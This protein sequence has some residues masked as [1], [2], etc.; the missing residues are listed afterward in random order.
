MSKKIQITSK[1]AA[2]FNFMLKQLRKIAK[3]YQTPKQLRRTDEKQLG[4]SYEECLEMAYENIQLEAARGAK[5]VKPI[6]IPVTPAA[7]KAREAAL[8]LASEAGLSQANFDKQNP[9]P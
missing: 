4:P 2:Q 3:D 5:R 8:Q 1:Q 7:R 6:R 9:Q